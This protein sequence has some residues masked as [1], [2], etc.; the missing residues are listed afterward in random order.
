MKER[1][2]A[3]GRIVPEKI[4]QGQAKNDAPKVAPASLAALLGGRKPGLFDAMN[5]PL[6]GL[7]PDDI[8]YAGE[9]DAALAAR[10][11][12]RA[13]IVSLLVLFLVIFL[14]GWAYVADIDEVTHAE[15]QVVASQRTQS[16]QNLEGGI[17]RKMNVREGQI[18]EKGDLLARLDNE[19]AEAS[20]RDAVAKA[21][22]NDLAIIRL[23]AELRGE[24]PKFPVDIKDFL[25]KKV[26]IA[27]DAQ[28]L[29]R[30][31]QLL[32]DQQEAWKTH[33]GLF[34]SE[35]QVLQSQLLQKE[36]EVEDQEARRTQVKQSLGIA[37]SQ[38]GTASELMR[39][40]SFA[41][42]EYLNLQQKVVDFKGQLASLE[43]NIPR[44]REA[45][46]EVRQRIEAKKAEDRSQLTQ[47]L[48]KRRIEL[49]SL[50][51]TI[52]AGGDRVKRTELRSPVRGTVKQI[53]INTVGGVVKP[54]EPIMDIVPLDD[55]LLIEARVKPQDVAFLRPDQDVMVKIS[56]YDFSIYGG[57]KG[58]LESISADTIEDKRGEFHYLVKVR[59]PETEIVH[60]NQHLPI[61][62]GMMVVADILTGKKTV[63]DYILKP[64][65]KAKQNALRER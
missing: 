49:N 13:S 53:H 33:Q 22:E 17:I 47:E 16:I 48:N 14:I 54:G 19:M 60:N 55:T 10:P 61:I 21:I 46:T 63:L 26:R 37:Q 35:L 59:T 56:A 43:A 34:K 11:G 50:R 41:K 6:E 42:M 38:L 23:E 8:S 15:G 25:V 44:A 39:R 45:V 29:A 65:L 52:S 24:D 36:R 57:L 32:K 18:V 30:A 64:I 2:T 4:P 31:A 3:V 58:R 27:P 20:Y 51:E 7:T 5:A 12:L 62:P 28:T 40:E 1:E 9:V